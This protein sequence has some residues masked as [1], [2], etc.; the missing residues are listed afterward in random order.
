MAPP[1]HLRENQKAIV[2]PFSFVE[3]MECFNLY[4]SFM[5]FS[6]YT[7]RKRSEEK[8]PDYDSDFPFFNNF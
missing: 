1:F 3:I 4:F 6:A 5:Y 7:E 8:V 2:L